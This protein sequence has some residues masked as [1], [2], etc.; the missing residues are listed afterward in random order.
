MNICAIW[1]SRVDGRRPRGVVRRRQNADESGIRHWF[2][3]VHE[4]DG[5]PPGGGGPGETSV[6]RC[7]PRCSLAVT[8]QLVSDANLCDD[9][10][11]LDDELADVR[12][13]LVAG[14]AVQHRHIEEGVARVDAPT[15]E[16]VIQVLAL[17]LHR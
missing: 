6:Q 8:H 15:A 1:V 12:V 13:E 9:P 10:A 3:T 16:N 11:V 4:C 17:S 14:G 2:V 5:N 7:P